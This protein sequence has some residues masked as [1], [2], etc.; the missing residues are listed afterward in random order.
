[1]NDSKRYNFLVSFTYKLKMQDQ[2][3][4]NHI[5]HQTDKDFVI[6]Y[7]IAEMRTSAFEKD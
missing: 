3:L 4:L 6:G 1:M 2:C 5:A 7:R